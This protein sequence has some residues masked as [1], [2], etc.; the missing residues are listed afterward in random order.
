M[1]KSL[2]I[3]NYAIIEEVMIQFNGQMN[4]ITGE[5]GAGKSIMLGALGLITG[6]RVDSAALLNKEEKCSVEAI[7]EM[8]DPIFKTFFQ[9]RDIDF[10]FE[11][12]IRR[13]ILPNG[14]SRA[15]IND[16]PVNLTVLKDLSSFLIEINSQNQSLELRSPAYQLSILDSF[17]EHEN[18]LND[19]KKAFSNYKKKTVLLDQLIDEEKKSAAELDFL[20]FQLNEI[21]EANLQGVQLPDLESELQTLQ[22]AHE[23]SAI[24]LQTVHLLDEGDT[25]IQDALIASASSLSKIVKFNPAIKILSERFEAIIIELKELSHEM[26][27]IGEQTEFNPIRIEEINQ[28]LHGVYKLLKKHH[29]NDIPSL[30]QFEEHLID[31]IKQIQVSNSSIEPL[32]KELEALHQDILQ[33][34]KLLS[35]QRNSQVK[36]IEKKV[37]Q[38]LSLLG[39]SNAILKIQIDTDFDQLKANGAD[40]IQFLFSANKGIGLKD[41]KNAISGGEMSRFLLSLKTVLAEKMQLPT[42]IFDEIDTGVSGDIAYKVGELLHNLS[43]KHQLI[44]ITH[45]PQIASKGNH[46]LFVFK[47]TKEKT[48]KTNIKLL[49]KEE[50]KIEIAKMLSGEKISDAALVNANELLNNH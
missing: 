8:K 27:N 9:E 2:E 45:L 16:S 44:A 6:E 7:F 50:R 3:K 31:K 32:K 24:L 20:Q 19:Y 40:E 29:L 38:N 21:G 17:A 10:E 34:A 1:L 46:H 33:K 42:I 41:I 22:N 37:M 25:N 13:E 12:I 36:M 23:I 11:T 15:F 49:Q 5:T 43:Q 47:E 4:I 18:L 48:T 26:K 35:T 39:M 28:I 14:K 30:M